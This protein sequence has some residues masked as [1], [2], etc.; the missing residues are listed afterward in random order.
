MNADEKL[1]ELSAALSDEH[2]L[3]RENELLR[4][5]LVHVR[6]IIVD[7]A[8]TG[9]NCRSGDWARR[10]YASQ[11][12]THAALKPSSQG[13]PMFLTEAFNIVQET[14]ER[15]GDTERPHG[16]ALEALLEIEEAF[17]ALF[18]A[19]RRLREALQQPVE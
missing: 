8:E 10:L 4:A 19:N 5:A 3:E 11:A 17:Q 2:R 18:A 16:A 1:Q 6:S 15:A 9:F 12:V 14:L 7:G 13:P